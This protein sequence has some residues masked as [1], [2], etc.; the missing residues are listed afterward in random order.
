MKIDLRSFGGSALTADI[1]VPKHR[2]IDL[3]KDQIPITYVPARNTIFLSIA[4]AYAEKLSI[5][6]IFIGVNQIDYSGYPD[7]RPE[8]VDSIQNTINLGTK[9]GVDGNSILINTIFFNQ[10]FNS[11]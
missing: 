8:F 7:C 9:V 1:E 10:Q 3:Q 6:E 2:N 4:S 5:Q 11:S